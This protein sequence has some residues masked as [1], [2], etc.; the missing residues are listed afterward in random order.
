MDGLIQDVVLS[1]FRAILDY[2]DIVSSATVG[3]EYNIAGTV[4]SQKRK[5]PPKTL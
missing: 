5:F 4:P 2:M 3:V 1:Y